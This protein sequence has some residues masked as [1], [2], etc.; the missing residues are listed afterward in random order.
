[1]GGM[2]VPRTLRIKGQRWR[3]RVVAGLK[4]REGVVGLCDPDERLIQIDAALGQRERHATLVHEIL[5]AC[6]PARVCTA[7]VEERLILKL[8]EPLRALIASGAL[9]GR[10]A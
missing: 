1:M 4:R 3:V 2:R 6:F 8:E 10:A 9:T 7:R 5:H